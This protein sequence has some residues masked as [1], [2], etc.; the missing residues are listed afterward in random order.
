MVFQKYFPVRSEQPYDQALNSPLPRE[1]AGA[2]WEHW[3]N[4]QDQHTNPGVGDHSQP[5]C[6]L[7]HTELCV[8]VP[9]RLCAW[10][11]V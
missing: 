9:P 4:V 8:E 11:W 5:T 1:A 3:E 10:L 7:P 2:A 6:G